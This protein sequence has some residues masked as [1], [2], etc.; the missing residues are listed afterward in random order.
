MSDTAEIERLISK[1][2]AH[3]S[4]GRQC[5]DIKQPVDLSALEAVVGQ[6]T[7]QL[8]KLPRDTTLG[9]RTNLIVLF[10]EIGQLD[11]AVTRLHRETGD[12]LKNMSSQ[13]FATSAY[14]TNPN[15]P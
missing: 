14:N 3:I 10:D 4:A 5:L 15:K 9:Q 12:R 11:E 13:R 2:R 1:A 7:E 8:A 6:I